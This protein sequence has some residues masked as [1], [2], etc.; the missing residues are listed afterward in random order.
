ML[1]FA[2]NVNFVNPAD[3]EAS[4][5][6][7]FAAKAA[8][9]MEM[10]YRRL[11]SAVFAFAYQS[12]ERTWV[13]GIAKN[14]RLEMLQTRGK[15]SARQA[16]TSDEELNQG[17]DNSPDAYALILSKQKVHQLVECFGQ[18]STEQ[19]SCLPQLPQYELKQVIVSWP[20]DKEIAANAGIAASSCQ[21]T[22]V[23]LVTVSEVALHKNDGNE[24]VSIPLAG[25]EPAIEIVRPSIRDGKVATPV[26]IEVRFKPVSGKAIDPS[27][28]KLY[29][30]SFKVDVT[31]R[32]LKTAKVIATGFSIDNVDIPSGNHRLMMK[33][34]DDEGSVGFKQIKFSVGS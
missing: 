19:Q 21:T 23:Q 14:K 34:G 18:L 8:S 22:P 25:D 20:L 4:L 7:A 3:F 30:D 15:T 10:L 16:D 27:S 26:G 29:Y 13:F 12:T 9:A 6:P 5:L 28:F 31:G 11:S 32:L 1:P 33:V 17:A 24:N 2:M